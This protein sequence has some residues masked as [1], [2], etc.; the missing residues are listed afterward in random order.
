MTPQSSIP[1]IT[2][3]GLVSLA[4]AGQHHHK[5]GGQLENVR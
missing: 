2:N 3:V 5:F 4:L 1:R